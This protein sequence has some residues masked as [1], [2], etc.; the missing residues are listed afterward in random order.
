MAGVVGHL[1]AERALALLDGDLTA[2]TG[3]VTTVDG[4][5]GA[6]RDVPLLP[7]PRCP[8][9]G[10]AP[11]HVSPNT[12]RQDQEFT[13]SVAIKIPTSLRRFVGGQNQ[14]DVSGQNVREALDG[15]EEAHPG[16][17][18]KICDAEGNLRRFINVYADQEDIRFLDN[19]ETHLAEG[20]ELQIVPA[21]AGG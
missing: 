12:H 19:L 21:I 3:F 6:T 15:L 4:L 9:C 8:A 10:G 17:K 5:R 14:V 13:M 1:Q 2:A 11:E 20:A 7:N 18:S 16:I